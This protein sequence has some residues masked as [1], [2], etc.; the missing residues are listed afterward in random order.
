MDVKSIRAGSVRFPGF[1]DER[2][3]EMKMS[4]YQAR[5]DE[6][7]LQVDVLRGVA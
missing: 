5:N 2:L 4:V 7:I 6:H 1:A 3:I